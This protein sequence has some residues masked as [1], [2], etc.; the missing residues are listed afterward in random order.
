MNKQSLGEEGTNCQKGVRE[1]R[2]ENGVQEKRLWRR[3][4]DEPAAR[5]IRPKLDMFPQSQV[6]NTLDEDGKTHVDTKVT[7]ESKHCPA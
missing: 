2:Q 6:R 4:S 1:K 5:A 7:N 3:S